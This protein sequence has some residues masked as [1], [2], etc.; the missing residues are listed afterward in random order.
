MNP[1]PMA[2]YW[3]WYTAALDRDRCAGR[4]FPAIA[5]RDQDGGTR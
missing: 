3:D 4:G 5:D 1:D 2:A